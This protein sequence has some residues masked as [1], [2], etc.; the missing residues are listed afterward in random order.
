MRRKY[1]ADGSPMVLSEEQV[2]ARWPGLPD[3]PARARTIFHQQPA[4]RIEVELHAEDPIGG[5]GNI[6]QHFGSGFDLEY[7]ERGTSAHVRPVE[8]TWSGRGSLDVSALLHKLETRRGEA[9]VVISFG[10]PNFWEIT[11]R[12]GELRGQLLLG[13][14]LSTPEWEI[15]LAQERDL[16]ARIKRLRSMGGVL[17]T[18]QAALRRPGNLPIGVNA[19]SNV[20]EALHY[21]FSFARGAWSG[22]VLPVG[23]DVTGAVVWEKWDAPKATGWSNAGTWLDRT[24]GEEMAGVLPGFL[25]RWDTPEWRRTVQRTVHW[26]VSA[27]QQSGAVDGAVVLAQT[28]LELL[29]WQLLHREEK[30]FSRLAFNDLGVEKSLRELLRTMKVAP[31]FPESLSRLAEAGSRRSEWDGPAAIVAVRNNIAHP[32][33]RGDESLAEPLVIADAWRLSLLYLELAL[34]YAFDHQGRYRNRFGPALGRTERVPWAVD[35]RDHAPGE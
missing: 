22:P 21:F 5:L 8:V 20:L 34:L 31:N 33:G 11:S 9:P 19:A 28:G 29:S 1:P 25:R 10:L 30:R 35:A 18:H 2:V 14:R 32:R 6:S 7:V 23:I 13:A 3:G 4:P 17:V 16:G 27:N 24:S 15:E 12:S 26:Y